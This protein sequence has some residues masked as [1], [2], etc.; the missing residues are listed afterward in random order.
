MRGKKGRGKQQRAKQERAK[1]ERQ[2]RSA[3][4]IKRPANIM[5]RGGQRG[6]VEVGR[7]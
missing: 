7:I 2:A 3:R 1:Q 5:G 4:K 6:R